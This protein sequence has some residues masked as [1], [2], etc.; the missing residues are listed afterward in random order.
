VANIVTCNKTPSVISHTVKIWL[1]LGTVNQLRQQGKSS[2][3]RDTSFVALNGLNRLLRLSVRD[4]RQSS[5]WVGD[6]WHSL[7]VPHSAGVLECTWAGSAV[8]CA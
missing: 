5:W 7:S 1:P 2:S 8:L 4:I 3:V 6:S